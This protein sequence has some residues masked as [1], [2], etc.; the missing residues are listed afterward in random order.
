[1]IQR[2]LG[3]TADGVFGPMT[4][5]AIE[6]ADAKELM[7]KFSDDFTSVRDFSQCYGAPLLIQ[8]CADGNVYLCPDQRHQEDYKIGTHF[9]EIDNIKTIWGGKLHKELVFGNT[10]AK[11]TTRCTVGIYCKM[12]EQVFMDE[13]PFDRW[14]V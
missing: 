4:M 8:L 12:C 2:A 14:F 9:P 7:H 3:V 10:P 5:A 13:D 1:M 11:C 6:K